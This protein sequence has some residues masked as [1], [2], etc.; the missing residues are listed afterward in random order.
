MPV[1]VG[2]HG[3]PPL[4]AI[5]PLYS[6]F[7]YTTGGVTADFSII[8]IIT[9]FCISWGYSFI[10][11]N[12]GENKI[13]LSNY[14]INIII[15]A[16]IISM[17]LV[18]SYIALNYY[19]NHTKSHTDTTSDKEAELINI[20]KSH[21][22]TMRDKFNELNRVIDTIGKLESEIKKVIK[23]VDEIKHDV[24]SYTKFTIMEDHV[25]LTASNSD[26]SQAI[27]KNIITRFKWGTVDYWKIRE[28]I[29]TIIKDNFPYDNKN[30]PKNDE[31]K[32]A[33]RHY[34]S[35]SKNMRELEK[36]YVIA[37]E[38]NPVFMENNIDRIQLKKDPNY[39][40]IEI[41]LKN[42][43]KPL[44]GYFSDQNKINS[45]TEQLLKKVIKLYGGTR[46]EIITKKDFIDSFVFYSRQTDIPDITES[47]VNHI[48]KN[49]HIITS[50][51]DA[52]SKISR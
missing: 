31:I 45:L 51:I 40:E 17:L 35:V 25:A 5:V 20:I 28:K 26:H 16:T 47:V 6:V 18:F 48:K 8:N 13:V 19:S 4:I 15:V 46:Y 50:E 30:N 52:N 42:A 34:H 29:Q 9:S 7:F 41:K 38:N 32:A 49:K 22:N 37:D 43:E 36:K 24:S 11:F 23:S 39:N 2:A 14:L 21:T 44:T 12:I 33:L 27:E 1:I 10:V 3:H